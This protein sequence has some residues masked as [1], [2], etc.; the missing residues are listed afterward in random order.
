MLPETLHSLRKSCHALLTP[1]TTEAAPKA[2]GGN[3]A[4]ASDSV[5]SMN[6]RRSV[7]SRAAALV[8]EA[9]D[10][11]NASVSA[12]N[13][14][15]TA[16]SSTALRGSGI[17]KNNKRTASVASFALPLDLE[18]EPFLKFRSSVEELL[19]ADEAGDHAKS[20][21]VRRASVNAAV[22]VLCKR[23]GPEIAEAIGLKSHAA[24]LVDTAYAHYGTVREKK[25][26][27]Q[28]AARRVA[29]AE[30]RLAAARD[31]DMMNPKLIAGVEAFTSKFY[32][33]SKYFCDGFEYRYVKSRYLVSTKVPFAGRVCMRLS[34][35]LP[36]SQPCDGPQGDAVHYPGGLSEPSS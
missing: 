35:R 33:S 26:A 17:A 22:E 34:T 11:E 12:G 15:V 30:S 31:E 28:T 20:K 13:G 4:T 29:E 1:L 36:L 8:A 32:Y 5:Q 9:D 3:L 2:A 27:V 23:G 21:R 7:R 6:R 16:S 14:R 25:A 19:D 18:D 10:K 24:E